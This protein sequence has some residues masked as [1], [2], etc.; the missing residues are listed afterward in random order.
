MQPVGWDGS[1]GGRAG[2]NGPGPG[3]TQGLTQALQPREQQGRPSAVAAHP[4]HGLGPW[5][6][7]EE[8][9]SGSSVGSGYGHSQVG[10]SWPGPLGRPAPHGPEEKAGRTSVSPHGFATRRGAP[11]RK[12]QEASESFEGQPKA[13][14]LV[15]AGRTRMYET[16]HRLALC[17]WPGARVGPGSWGQGRGWARQ[18][19]RGW[20]A[21][22]GDRVSASVPLIWGPPGQDLDPQQ[23]PRGFLWVVKVIR[24]EDHDGQVRRASESKGL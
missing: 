16:R 24:N 3:R 20:Q 22:L 12:N 23:Q 14:G 13:P 6:L 18:G 4:R 10:R 7:G 9:G 5:A 15:L 19:T 21:A 17:E 2:M 11:C 1:W 8:W